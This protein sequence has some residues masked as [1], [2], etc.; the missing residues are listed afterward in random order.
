MTRLHSDVSACGAEP[1]TEAVGSTPAQTDR[2]RTNPACPLPGPLTLRARRLGL[3]SHSEPIVILR[4]DSAI[5]RSEGLAP[6]S[7]VEL[8][9]GGRSVVATLFQ[10]DDVLDRDQVGLSESAWRL[11]GLVEGATVRVKQAPPIASIASIRRRIYGHRLKLDDMTA[12]VRDVVDGRYADLHLAAF[13]T[14]TAAQ[15]MDEEESWALTKAMVASG[16][17]LDWP[18]AI[19]VDKHCVGGLPG[20]RTTP[21]IVAIVAAGGL[22]MPKTSSRAI[23]S[24]AGTADVM[25]VLAPVDLPIGAMRRVVEQVGGCIVWGGAIDLSPADDIFIGVERALDID[26]EGQ[27]VASVLSKKIAAGATH[28]VLD[29]PVGPTAKVRSAAAAADLA[30]RLTTIA[31]RFDMRAI[32]I[33]SDGTQPV[34]RAL[35]PALEAAD[36]LAVLNNDPTAP[37]DLR[38]RACTL[39]AILLEAGGAALPGDGALLAE[40]LLASGA[41]ARKFDEICEA[42]GGRRDLPVSGYRHSVTTPVGGMVTA[43]DNR[44]IAR[45][46]KLAGAPDAPAA[47]LLLHAQTGDSLC[48]GDP[49]FTLHAESPGELAYALDY[50]VAN[51]DIIA[52]EDRG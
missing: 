15:P 12:I 2:P 45:L 33:Q 31:G 26:T 36:V 16:E 43:I 24:P 20:N 19:V 3:H 21:I 38:A 48:G 13:L 37:Q 28:V 11:L 22:T 25:A 17:R 10:V 34:G 18:F 29:I 51:P 49:L 41:A 42:Q 9:A 6:H 5:C 30:R 14:A 40:Q 7:R 32:C 39:A 52:L 27:L 35:G 4:T 50:A 1:A 47:G 8:H 44:R 46:A 23:T